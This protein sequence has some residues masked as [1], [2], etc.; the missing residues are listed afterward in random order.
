MT[1]YDLAVAGIG[2]SRNTLPECAEAMLLSLPSLVD[3]LSI[4]ILVP[5]APTA[6]LLGF[7]VETVGGC[8]NSTFTAV[9]E[10]LEHGAEAFDPEADLCGGG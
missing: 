6:P 9:A 5:I 7:I 3:N 1:A 4:S 10:V 8:V 2:V